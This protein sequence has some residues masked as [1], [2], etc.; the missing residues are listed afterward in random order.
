MNESRAN[1]LRYRQLTKEQKELICNGCG[2]KGGIINPPNFLFKASCNHHDF[3]YW[4][5]GSE[6]DR[7]KADN[8]F[9]EKMKEDVSESHWIK[10]PFY[11]FTAWLYYKSVRRFGKK[12]FEYSESQKT[13]EDLFKAM[14]ENT[15]S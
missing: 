13:H 1:R 2:G 3:Y 9:Y 4:R 12:F 6:D 5:G 15:K 10:K 7:T 8:Q 14:K 11:S